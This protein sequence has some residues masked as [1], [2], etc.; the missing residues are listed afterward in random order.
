MIARGII[1]IVFRF[2][3]YSLTLSNLNLPA[4]SSSIIQAANDCHNPK[5]QKYFLNQPA[6]W[7]PATIQPSASRQP[8]SQNNPSYLFKCMT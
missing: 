6:S 1:L 8:A 4:K 3:R 7:Q 5:L 2:L